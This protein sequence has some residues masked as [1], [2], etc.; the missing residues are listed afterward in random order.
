[1]DPPK[2]ETEYE[3]HITRTLQSADPT[4]DIDTLN[5]LIINT[6]TEAQGQLCKREEREERITRETMQKIEDRRKLVRDRSSDEQTIRDANREISK[7]VR[8][9]IRNYKKQKILQTIEQTKNM[10]VLRRKL[11]GGKRE[12]IKLRNKEGQ[13]TSNREEI[14]HITETFYETLYKSQQIPNSID[15]TP[16]KVVNQGSEDIPDISKD[17]IYF[18]LKKMKNNR[19]PGEDGVVI[20][21]IKLGELL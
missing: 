8:K 19:A 9:D 6:V 17:E 2:D 7:A 11:K 12:I 20:E 15:K 18:A 10:K 13:L 5:S 1:M 3:T 14:I 16:P 4:D 21:A